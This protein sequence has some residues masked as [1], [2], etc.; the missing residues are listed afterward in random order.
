MKRA[1]RD[2]CFVDVETTGLDPDRHELLEVAAIRVDP[3]LERII[4]AF[5]TKVR[6]TCPHMATAEAIQVNG[7]TEAGWHLAAS[8]GCAL[9]NVGHVISGAMLAGHNVAFD[10]AFL[11]SGY[12][13]VGVEMPDV[14]HRRLDT[15]SLAWPLYASGELDSLSLDAICARLG[16]ERPSPHRAL[17]DAQA[18]LEVARR[19]CGLTGR[20]A[21]IDDRAWVLTFTGR[22]V[23]LARPRPEDL[24]I[25]D[26]SRA[27]A[28]QCRF[29]GQI[30]EP[31]SV[32]RHSV[33]VSELAAAYARGEGRPDHE[34]RDVARQGLLHDAGEAYLGDV[35]SPLKRMLP[36]LQAL[37][38]GFWSAIC[39]KWGCPEELDPAVKRADLAILRVE[40][41]EQMAAHL[42]APD[43]LTTLPSCEIA[44]SLRGAI[45][46]RWG[47]RGDREAFLARAEELGV[48]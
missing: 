24:T 42:T 9:A 39:E 26:I 25:A 8:L 32:A 27:L 10:A 34:V 20:S 38:A 43:F 13:R 3:S 15:L 44:S 48:S 45:T 46:A 1:R 40:M 11:E 33:L 47:W 30:L 22:R 4:D 17:V 16:I 23:P 7:Y 29:N 14:G 12:A 41:V 35:V 36:G 21:P 28:L 5:S 31:Y 18:S 19:L 2:I 6:P 37:E